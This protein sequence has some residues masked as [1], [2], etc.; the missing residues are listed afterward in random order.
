MSLAIC[1][2]ARALARHQPQ[3]ERCTARAHG[4]IIVMQPAPPVARRAGGRDCRL[5]SRMPRAHPWSRLRGCGDCHEQSIPCPRGAS[6]A[7]ALGVK[8]HSWGRMVPDSAAARPPCRR[9]YDMDL[10][11][12]R[13]L[14][15]QRLTKFCRAGFVSVTDF[16]W[17]AH[18][19]AAM[20]HA[21]PPS[22]AALWPSQLLR[23]LSLL[24][25]APPPP[26]GTTRCASLPR[27]RSLPS[28]IP[29][30]PPR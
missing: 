26:P 19:A 4:S 16:R 18:A 3:R 24:P 29:A 21:A 10:R 8:F 20:P 5:L 6:P 22:A 12:E 30:W 1:L 2:R 25:P 28:A 27:M 23:P 15:L 14:A 17:Q 9:R 11:D 13:E 7:A